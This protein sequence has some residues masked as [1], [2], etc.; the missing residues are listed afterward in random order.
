MLDRY[1]SIE[2]DT[3]E[4][5]ASS[6]GLSCPDSDVRNSYNQASGLPQLNFN[7]GN[8]M[9]G[10][11]T[12]VVD[13]SVYDPVVLGLLDDPTPVIL[14]ITDYS[15]TAETPFII[16]HTE[17][18]GDLPPDGIMKLRVALLE[19]NLSYGGRTYH[20]VLRDMLP[21]KDLNIGLG[22]QSQDD[23]LTF[24]MDPAW[25]ASGVRAIAFVQNDR[26]REIFQ[27]CNTR[28][29]PA[30]S[31]R[32]Y[33][34]GPRYVVAEGTTT[35]GEA[36][37]F[38][39]GT[40]TD[41]YT[42]SLDT[43]NLPASGSAYFTCGGTQYTTM[44]VSLEPGERT[45]LTVTLDPGD[46][47]EG[48]V[49][50]VLHSH[51]GEITDRS[52]VYK[53][54]RGDT[55]ILMVDDDGSY[56]YE[57]EYFLPAM[58]GTN[59]SHATWNRSVAPVTGAQLAEFDIVVWACGWAFPTV[60]AADRAA[61]TEYLDGGGNL[62]ITGQDIG[63]EMNDIGGAA[64]TWYNT[65]LHA[66]YVS[67][68]TNDLTL[69]GVAGTFTEGLSLNIGGGDGADNQDYPSDIDPRGEFASEILT[70][71]AGRNGGIMADTG[72]HRVVYLAFGFEAIDNAADRAALM[73]GIIGFLAGAPSPVGE[74]EM[75]G[76]MALLGNNPNPFN[77]LTRISFRLADETR[78]KLQ[79][80]DLHGHLV[81][82]LADENLP[83]G[84]NSLEW[85]GRDEDGRAMP[86]GA[87]F[88][89]LTGPG[90]T[91]AGKMM[92]VR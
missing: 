10:A 69:D 14:Q 56:D 74:T 43:S 46:E 5:L 21:D 11:G 50:L 19:D 7:G 51:S 67:D 44:E 33:T 82:T 65:Y 41:T 27:S 15:F 86:S 75:P 58:A 28:P 54:I 25:N 90:R 30:F 78:V 88:Y 72:V 26:D 62:F 60:D 2:F 61:L 64:R 29:T 32:Y 1:D 71:S 81:R 8:T 9:V 53:V 16:L 13:G 91:L 12:D 76:A 35:F 89:R 22:G 73:E 59:K 84:L 79:V 49:L 23:T 80:Y 31:M 40:H 85:D 45:L 38:N 39:M 18:E 83:A 48:E 42:V 68:D 66:T 55:D 77:P 70:Y 63:W 87:F 52:L 37:L 24:T 57:T 20:N 6:G 36:G 3:V 4:Y 17:L 92:L 47:T 34:D